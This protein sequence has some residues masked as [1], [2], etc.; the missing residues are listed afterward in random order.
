MK[1][2]PAWIK[3]SFVPVAVS[4][5]GSDSEAAAAPAE[6]KEVRLALGRPDTADSD[7]VGVDENAQTGVQKIEATTSAWG[8][9]QLVLAYILIFLIYFVDS[10]QQQLTSVLT[11]YVTSDFRLHSLTATTGILSQIIGGLSKLPLAK[12]LDIW[13]RP[14]GFILM[15][16]LLTIGLVMM[17]AC[18]N[19]ETYAAA[20]VFY[21]VGYNGVGYALSIF[22]ADTSHL[23]N[24]GLMFAF[25]SS[26]YIATTWAG[27]PAA[28]RFLEGAGFRW[29]FGTFAIVTPAVCLPVFFLFVFNYREAKKAG[30][31]PTRQSDRTMIQAIQHY[32]IEFDLFGLLLITAGLALFL[33]PFS[34]YSYQ[35]DG[36][37]SS[38]IIC[39]IIF[40]ALLLV[41]FGLWEKYCAPKKFIPWELFTDRTV[42]G[43]NILAAVLFVSFYIWDSFFYSF[44]IV[45]NNQTI[46]HASYITNIYSIG[47]CFFAIPVGM[48]IRWRGHFK[49]IALFFGVPL[50]ILGV[51]L[52]LRFRQPNTHIGYVIMC[53]IF[54]A[55][56]GGT[57]VIC[58]QIAVMAAAS[59]QHVAVVI[60][61]EGMFS[62]VGGAIGSTIA[63]AIWTGNFREKL[64]TYLPASAQGDIDSIYGSLVV[65]SS[66]P[67]GTPTRE[68]INRAYG[69]TQKLMLIA[70]TA[71]LALA[72]VSVAMWRN[73]CVKDINQV[74]GR[75]A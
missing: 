68:A 57:L 62:S 60:A 49:N 8:R 13:G 30:L 31:M 12:I 61:I 71:F 23:K 41:G 28:Q 10:L 47:A 22:I 53:Q 17:A 27:G 40:G 7:S 65:Q 15:V 25:A 48:Y 35:A 58:E 3:P 20:Q 59:H 33:L 74:R 66:Y 21:W 73:I 6:S 45:V 38:M 42:V 32:A 50:T 67:P 18:Q 34:L 46:T 56:A 52:M 4:Q 37:R 26:P 70:S 5:H 24:R 29:G 63:T 1:F 64:S 44:L 39:M 54:I 19:V 69:D 75:V 14:Q 36:W 9:N 11:P 16:A 72:I 55:F 51:A 2:N 43:A